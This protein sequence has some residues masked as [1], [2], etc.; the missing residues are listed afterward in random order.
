VLQVKVLQVT[1]KLFKLQT[2]KIHTNSLSL[3]TSVLIMC[4]Q[5]H[6]YSFL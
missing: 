5:L 1:L 4:P 3:I 2:L 6:V